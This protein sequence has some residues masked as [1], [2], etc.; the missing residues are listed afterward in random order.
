M[1]SSF[2]IEYTVNIQKVV[3]SVY[4][5]NS[6]ILSKTNCRDIESWIIDLGD[7][8]CIKEYIPDRA[9]VLGVFFTHTHY[10][11]IY[12]LND[13]LSIYP[14]ICLLTNEVGKKALCSP[15][16]NYSRYHH[17][18]ANIICSKPENIEIIIDGDFF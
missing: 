18:T 7:V 14:D 9:N 3:N 4:N 6:Y 10:D 12:G 17:E 5:S 1:V 2:N 16:L 8:N 15:K 11:H 13:F